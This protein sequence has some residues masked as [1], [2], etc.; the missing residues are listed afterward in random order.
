MKK[1]TVEVK[2]VKT[3]YFDLSAKNKREAKQMI[4]SLCNNVNLDNSCLEPFK[5][6][7]VDIV[8]G[9]FKKK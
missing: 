9:R 1:F 8:F 3:L 4:N 2:Q 6:K 7:N 5:L